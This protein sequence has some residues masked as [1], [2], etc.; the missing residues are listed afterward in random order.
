MNGPATES[1]AVPERAATEPRGDAA[2]PLEVP[3][4]P[5][6]CPNCG[7]AGM[8]RYC[9]D[10]GQAA[11]APD[12]Y[13]LRAHAADLWDQVAS[14]DG[15]A[16]RTLWTL[17]RRPGLLTADHLRGR[18]GRYLKPLQLFLLVNV[19]LFVAAPRIPFFSYSLRQYIENAPPSPSLVVSMVRR[20]VPGT[21]GPG[22]SGSV[23]DAALPT[24][25]RVPEAYEASFNARVEAQRKSLVILLAPALALLLRL[26]LVGRPAP[27]S[28]PRRY[29]EHLV[30]SLHL[31]AFVWLVLSVSYG[32]GVA[33]GGLLGPGAR[34]PVVAAVV[35]L[36]AAPPVH[37]FLALR[38]AYALRP[39]GALLLTAVLGA[40]FVALLVAYR[41]LLF[42]TTYWS[43]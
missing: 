10:C 34:L 30:F 20:A 24:R 28:A 15:K 40:G 13:S 12:D 33:L 26:L 11:P 6:L 3:R 41:G 2:G 4:R 1:P 39:A 29:G 8:A 42:F 27:P 38:R 35:A 7:S 37:A 25:L 18:R 14:V 21:P 23:L 22:P 9:P 17:L 36:L 43:L 31:L 16:L 19:L 5:S 32:A